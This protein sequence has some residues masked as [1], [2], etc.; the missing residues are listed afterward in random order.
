MKLSPPAKSA[1]GILGLCRCL[2]A[3]LSALYSGEALQVPVLP[4]GTSVL[5]LA[6]ETLATVKP[7]GLWV[8]LVCCWYLCLLALEGVGSHGLRMKWIGVVGLLVETEL[9]SSF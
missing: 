2:M 4:W 6:W 7:L 5:R 9:M 3:Q 8:R 1:D